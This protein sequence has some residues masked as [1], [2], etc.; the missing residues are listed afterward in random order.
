MPSWKELRDYLKQEGF[1]LKRIS[2]DEIWERVNHDGTL[3]RVRCLKG[4]GEIYG[5]LWARIRKHELGGITDAEFNRRRR[6]RRE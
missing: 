2:K 3:D 4:S 1:T 5:G 6:G